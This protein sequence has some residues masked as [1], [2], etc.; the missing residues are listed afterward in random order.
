[1]FFPDVIS[2]FTGGSFIETRTPDFAISWMLLSGEGSRDYPCPWSMLWED[3]LIIRQVHNRCTTGHIRQVHDRSNVHDRCTFDQG[4]RVVSPVSPPNTESVPVR[5]RREDAADVTGDGA[6][7]TS[8]LDVTS[9][10]WWAGVA[11]KSTKLL[12]G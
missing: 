10:G 6:L 1:M 12:I 8:S 5:P 7:S 9:G 11:H 4:K 2:G 3:D